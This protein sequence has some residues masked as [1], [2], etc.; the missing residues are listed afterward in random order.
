MKIGE[1]YANLAKEAFKPVESV[2]GEFAARNVT[3]GSKTRRTRR[4]L[5][6]DL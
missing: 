3:Q 2:Q 5:P 4:R 6:I 1:L